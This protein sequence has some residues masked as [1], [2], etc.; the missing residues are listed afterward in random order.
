[1]ICLKKVLY[2]IRADAI[3]SMT[4]NSIELYSRNEN[5][6]ELTWEE[7]AAKWWNWVFS[8]PIPYTPIDGCDRVIPDKDGL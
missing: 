5:P 6:F 1:M 8:I 4:Q 2:S 3:V 7:W